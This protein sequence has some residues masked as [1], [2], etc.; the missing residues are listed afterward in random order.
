MEYLEQK[1]ANE[2]NRSENNS[3]RS[4]RVRERNL[5][6]EHSIYNEQIAEQLHKSALRERNGRSTSETRH[7][8]PKAPAPTKP[9]READRRRALSK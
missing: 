2:P 8:P 1:K 3:Q 7:L 9:A 4:S 5:D 6:E